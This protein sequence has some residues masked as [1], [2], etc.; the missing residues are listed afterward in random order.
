MMV[1]AIVNCMG[2]AKETLTP[3]KLM[4]WLREEKVEPLISPADPPQTPEQL[5][6]FMERVTREM[7]GTIVKRES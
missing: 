2:G 3:E 6:E 5:R 7:G 4:P 1:C